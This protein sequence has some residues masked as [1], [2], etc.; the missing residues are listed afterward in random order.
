[1]VEIKQHPELQYKIYGIIYP[2]YSSKVRSHQKSPRKRPP[3]PCFLDYYRIDLL[4]PIDHSSGG[5][6]FVSSS[7][8]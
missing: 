6:A 4:S 8:Q 2:H 7:S 1:M 5:T 3:T